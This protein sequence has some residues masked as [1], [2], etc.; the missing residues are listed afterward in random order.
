MPSEAEALQA[1]YAALSPR[2]RQVLLLV[3]RSMEAAQ[4]T[5][6]EPSCRPPPE[7]AVGAAA[8]GTAT[9]L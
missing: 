9:D 7:S 8:A 5:P 2:N 6:S 1:I 3:A 4:R